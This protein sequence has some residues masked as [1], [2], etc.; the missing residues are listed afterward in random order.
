MES[1]SR[2]EGNFRG[3][4]QKSF[5]I[6]HCHPSSQMGMPS[7]SIFFFLFR[8]PHPGSTWEC[9]RTLERGCE[10]SLHLWSFARL[11][12]SLGKVAGTSWLGSS[13]HLPTWFLWRPYPASKISGSPASEP[14][15][16]RR[17]IPPAEYPGD[18]WP[19]P[20]HMW[21]HLADP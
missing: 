7:M 13:H 3:V 9:D 20:L 8:P 21:S 5:E 12:S 11:H 15:D 1:E 17:C 4:F 18:G 10:Y 19:E 16:S 6:Y 2:L 14:Q